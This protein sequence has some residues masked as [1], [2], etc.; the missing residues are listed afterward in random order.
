[1]D[2]YIPPQQKIVHE[3][4]QESKQRMASD[5]RQFLT[6]NRQLIKELR[7]EK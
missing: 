6:L 2:Y 1:M 3:V 5:A 7:K 4:I